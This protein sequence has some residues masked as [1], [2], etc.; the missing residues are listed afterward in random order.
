MKK[1]LATA[2][3]I[4]SLSACSIVGKASSSGEG[5]AFG[6]AT[7]AT[8][9][10]GHYELNGGDA[11]KT[12]VLKSSGKDMRNEIKKAFNNYDVIVFDGSQGDFIVSK[13]IDLKNLKNKSFIG[14]HDAKIRSEFI[15][16]DEIIEVLDSLGVKEMSAKDGGGT[17]SNGQIIKEQREF[18]TRQAIINLT[19]D[20]SETI[21]K[22][23]IFK[24]SACENIIFQNIAFQGPGP[25]DVSGADL[26]SIAGGSHHIWV[27]HCSFTDGMDGNLDITDGSDFITVSYCTFQY[28]DRAYDHKASNL[29]SSRKEPDKIDNYNITFAYCIWSDGCNLRMPVAR[30]GTIHLFNNYY[31]CSGNDNPSI[32][33]KT[34]SEFL[35]EGNYFAPGVKKIFKADSDA[36]AWVFKNNIFSEKFNPADQGTVGVPYSYTVLPAQEIP[37]K[38]SAEAG[39]TL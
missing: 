34:D 24:L 2:F 19:G 6:W 35:I 17:L 32:S 3:I 4:F 39:P 15:V 33:A 26:L 7:M 27:D 5:K 9:Q 29:I 30:Y 31:N 1:L 21:R 36:K 12:I 37:T 18:N 16:S 38:L 20:D 11:T 13:Y 14:I 8:L 25:I 23:G 10:G 28:T 22:S